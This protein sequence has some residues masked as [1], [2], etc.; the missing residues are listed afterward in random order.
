MTP[1]KSRLVGVERS[2]TLASWRIPTSAIPARRDWFSLDL[3][4]SLAQARQTA[5]VVIAGR[6]GPLGMIVFSR[7]D[8]ENL[9]STV[10]L[11]LL[12]SRAP[13]MA[14]SPFFVAPIE[15]ADAAD[16][17]SIPAHAW[18][19]ARLLGPG[20][21][22]TT[23]CGDKH[24]SL[25]AD[26]AALLVFPEVPLT[27]VHTV[28]VRLRSF[29]NEDIFATA[30]L[31]PA[32]FEGGPELAEAAAFEQSAPQCVRG[33][34]AVSLRL[35][36]PPALAD[37]AVALRAEPR[38]LADVVGVRCV[39][40]WLL[41]R[42]RVG[43][44]VKLGD[45]APVRLPDA[46]FDDVSLDETY[47]DAQ[48]RHLDVSLQGLSAGAL[49]WSRVKFKLFEERGAAGLEF[50]SGRFEE[51]CFL[52][53]P[54]L[55]ADAFGDYYKLSGAGELTHAIAT[56]PEAAD[57]RLLAAIRTCLPTL[58]RALASRGAIGAAQAVDWLA[59]ANTLAAVEP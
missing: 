11:R 49:N 13:R 10:A 4:V 29:D 30:A 42:S 19:G 46:C 43:L 14:R 37:V 3:P 33:E 24:L 50:R 51:R 17:V 34:A 26:H 55:E 18:T 59:L 54:G 6:L 35:T 22:Q 31:L 20:L 52:H 48:Y 27:D 40:V 5:A 15:T 1:S 25:Q 41:R 53:W 58:V 57:R 7:A 23:A 16:A 47:S 36:D 28:A 2:E 39:G 38:A 21:L 12:S 45:F 56:L 44:A 32:G 8:P 9:D